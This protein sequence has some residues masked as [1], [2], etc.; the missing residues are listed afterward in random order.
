MSMTVV[1]TLIL[2]GGLLL[3][4][5][6]W[7]ALSIAAMADDMMEEDEYARYMKHGDTNPE[8]ADLANKEE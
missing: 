1:F 4:F 2:T 8:Q 3:L 5:F 7:C 6:I